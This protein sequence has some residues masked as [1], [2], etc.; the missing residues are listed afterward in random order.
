MPLR[1]TPTSSPADAE[2]K[3]KVF[4]SGSSDP[5]VFGSVRTTLIISNKEIEDKMK[6]VKNLEESGLLIKFV[7]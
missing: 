4:G 3:L 1:L 5:N 7:Y 2:I 6:I